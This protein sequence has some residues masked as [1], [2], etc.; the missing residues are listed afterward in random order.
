MRKDDGHGVQPVAQIMRDDSE[1]DQQ[2][3]LRAGLEADADRDPVEEAVR[4]QAGRGQRAQFRLMRV[5]GVNV[6]AGAMQSGVALE[7]EKGQEADRGNR[8]VG[9][10][11][12]RKNL[13]QDVEQRNCQ[14]GAG[15]ETEQ[16]MEAV[17]KPNRRH[18]AHNR[19]RQR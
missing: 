8:H 18:P 2:T 15:A 9:W 17:A 16:Q 12:E 6:F 4:D 11:A 19:S 14:H 7:P 5:F 3:D 1:R 13:G 10:S